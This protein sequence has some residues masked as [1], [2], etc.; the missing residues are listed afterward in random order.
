MNQNLRQDHDQK[1]KKRLDVIEF[2]LSSD[3][4]AKCV[5]EGAEQNLLKQAGPQ[6]IK[7]EDQTKAA[8]SLTDPD[9]RPRFKRPRTIPAP[10]IHPIVR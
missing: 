7:Q 2:F 10:E 9:P 6:R 8:A 3:F 4:D 1:A 5:K